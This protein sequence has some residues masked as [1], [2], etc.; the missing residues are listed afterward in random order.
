MLVQNDLVLMQPLG[1]EGSKVRK[2]L[3]DA[4][5]NVTVISKERGSRVLLITP[6]NGSYSGIKRIYQ[7]INSLK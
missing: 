4:N 2:L 7:Y 6:E 1:E 5:L 3:E